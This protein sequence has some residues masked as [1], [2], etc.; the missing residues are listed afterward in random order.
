MPICAKTREMFQPVPTKA[1]LHLYN[2]TRSYPLQRGVACYAALAL[3]AQCAHYTFKLVAYPSVLSS[4]YR[5]SKNTANST[6]I[7][8][9]KWLD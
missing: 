8:V 3:R 2:A 7:I 9:E 5:Y 6:A 4:S 1:V